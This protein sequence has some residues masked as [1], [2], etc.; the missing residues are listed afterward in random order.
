M[1]KNKRHTWCRPL[2]FK[3]FDFSQKKK[4][5]PSNA[6]QFRDT[7]SRIRSSWSPICALSV[8]SLRI[9]L[10][11][12][13]LGRRHGTAC[14][15]C[16]LMCSRHECLALSSRYKDMFINTERVKTCQLTNSIWSCY[17]I[18]ILICALQRDVHASRC[19]PRMLGQMIDGFLTNAS[20]QDTSLRRA[21]VHRIALFVSPPSSASWMTHT[22]LTTFPSLAKWDE[23]Y[24]GHNC[25]ALALWNVSLYQQSASKW[26]QNV[27]L[28]NYWSYVKK[29][30]IFKSL[31]N[32]AAY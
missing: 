6:K 7:T 27:P 29:Q 11:L 23:P 16:V 18:K 8:W 3:V 10:T 31:G 14:R 1:I 28:L 32:S 21:N 2:L 24:G 12:F 9:S 17:S 25:T 15:M 30:N 26:V 22:R 13:S 20:W 4:K 19:D 5:K